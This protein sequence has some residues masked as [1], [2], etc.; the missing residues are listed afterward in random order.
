MLFIAQANNWLQRCTWCNVGVLECV[1]VVK[2]DDE[3]V[4]IA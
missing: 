4:V 2:A 1:A 3:K